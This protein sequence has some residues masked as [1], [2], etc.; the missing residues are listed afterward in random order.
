MK[1]SEEVLAEEIK[2]MC[3]Q[4]IAH[5]SKQQDLILD[6]YSGKEIEKKYLREL[7]EISQIDKLVKEKINSY[8]FEDNELDG[9]I[10]LEVEQLLAKKVHLVLKLSNNK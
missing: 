2:Q 8:T 5:N 1:K 7:A 3:D 10:L 9:S 6:N 4:S